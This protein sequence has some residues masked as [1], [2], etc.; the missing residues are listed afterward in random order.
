MLKTNYMQLDNEVS[1]KIKVESTFKV[2]DG[3]IVEVV[4]NDTTTEVE[5]TIAIK[6]TITHQD[7]DTDE[8]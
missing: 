5:I 8:K 7:A 1:A 4:K 2:E 3:A 6:I